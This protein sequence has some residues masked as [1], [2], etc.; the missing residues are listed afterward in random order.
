MLGGKSVMRGGAKG[1]GLTQRL[2]FVLRCLLLGFLLRCLLLDIVLRLF[3]LGFVRR[4]GRS[5]A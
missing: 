1:A 4:C 5:E 2:G 3:L